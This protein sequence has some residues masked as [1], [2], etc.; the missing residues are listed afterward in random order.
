MQ[1]AKF[2][3][4]QDMQL[5]ILALPEIELISPPSKQALVPFLS[6]C[7]PLT[8]HYR[9]IK[10]VALHRTDQSFLESSAAED[11]ESAAAP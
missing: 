10:L 8:M 11:Q 5:V 6:S 9:C 3:D 4:L 7:S 2:T 1:N